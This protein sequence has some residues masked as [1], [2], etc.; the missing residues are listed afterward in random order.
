MDWRV[1]EARLLGVDLRFNTYAEATDV[2]ALNPDVVVVATGG[3]PNTD[4]LTS[5]GALVLDTWEVMSG[6]RHPTGTVLVY[7]DNGNESA[8]GVAEL[9]A[10]RGCDVEIVTPERM[11]GIGIGGMNS[12]AYLAAFADYDVR[13]TLATRLRSVTRGPGGLVAELGSDYTPRTWQRQV[14]AVI[15]EHGTV[16][17]DELYN[18]MVPGS[19]NLGE[20]DQDA[21]LGDR[22]QNVRTNPQGRYQLFRIGDAVA[23]RNIH[24]AIYDALRLCAPM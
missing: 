10:E 14:D 1:S 4:I 12:P 20:V 16:P 22:R 13:M 7:D 8:L 17:N 3:T 23:S 11:L 19:V 21:L 9:L 18:D 2:R 5:G 24:A 6:D 15:V